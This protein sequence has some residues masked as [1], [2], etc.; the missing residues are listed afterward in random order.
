MHAYQREDVPERLRRLFPLLK[1]LTDHRVDCQ[2]IDF[3][4]VVFTAPH[5]LREKVLRHRASLWAC[6][7]SHK[8]LTESFFCV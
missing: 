6:A 5:E 2:V 4:C 7:L 1:S 8:L 3:V